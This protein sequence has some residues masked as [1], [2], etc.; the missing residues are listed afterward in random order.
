MPAWTRK[1]KHSRGWSEPM[2]LT[3]RAYFITNILPS[4]TDCGQIRA[5][6][7]SS[8]GWGLRREPAIPV[9]PNC[10][11][12]QIMSLFDLVSL[13]KN[14]YGRLPNDRP[15]QFKFNG[16]YRT[17]WK[18]LISGNWYAQSGAADIMRGITKL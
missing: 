2:M 6:P 16:T 15:H 17:P 13:L 7:T 9:H 5:S 14:L 1:T 4:L 10:R 18:V 11:K 12:D 3:L 8:G